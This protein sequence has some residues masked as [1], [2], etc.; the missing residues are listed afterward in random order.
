MSVED[1]RALLHILPAFPIF[2]LRW[3]QLVCPNPL[4]AEPLSLVGGTLNSPQPW[5][6]MVLQ[7]CIPRLSIAILPQPAHVK[8]KMMGQ[9]GKD[10]GW[11]SGSTLKQSLLSLGLSKSQGHRR[12]SCPL[13]LLVSVL[14]LLFY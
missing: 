14:N 10:G 1:E 11:S 5:L 12:R 8:E 6:L 7:D 9:G 4:H 3:S 13:P 2:S